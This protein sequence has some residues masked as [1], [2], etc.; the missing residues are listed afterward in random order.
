MNMYMYVVYLLKCTVEVDVQTFANTIHTCTCTFFA[1]LHVVGF[2]KYCTVGNMWREIN[3]LFV[4]VVKI[5]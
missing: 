5:N 3:F 2:P 4:S 1:G